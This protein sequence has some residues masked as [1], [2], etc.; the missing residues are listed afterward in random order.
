MSND[1]K[2]RGR[3]YPYCEKAKR[4]LSEEGTYEAVIRLENFHED[5]E[6]NI[7]ITRDDFE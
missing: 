2:A 7:E 3:L 6:L 4:T 1:K 5:V